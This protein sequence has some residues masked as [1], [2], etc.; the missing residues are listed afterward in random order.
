[1]SDLY[2]VKVYEE[3]ALLTSNFYGS[4]YTVRKVIKSTKT[5]IYIEGDSDTW[6]RKRDGRLPGR[7]EIWDR[8]PTITPLTNRIRER[9]KKQAIEDHRRDAIR[10]LLA[11]A[12][13]P[14][15][16]STY[17]IEAALL[18]LEAEPKNGGGI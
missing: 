17:A 5:R 10:K 6:Y 12:E 7:K 1:M 9:I 15:K 11:Y 18:M 4:R 13:H 14:E 16:I 8:S 2:E 3:V